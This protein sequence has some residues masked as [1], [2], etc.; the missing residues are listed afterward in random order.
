MAPRLH[1]LDRRLALSAGWALFAALLLLQYLVFV[2]RAQREITWAYPMHFDQTG[3]L[4]QSYE[5]FEVMRHEG[6]FRG[7]LHGL[8]VNAAQGKLLHLQAA[9][10]YLFLGASRLSALTLNFLYFALLQ[11]FAL[12]TTRWLTR[13]WAAGWLA[14]GFV[15]ASRTRLQPAGGMLDFRI[16]FI[17][18]C[19]VGILICVVI[20]SGVFRYR[21]WSLAAGAAAAVLIGFRFLS[22]VLVAPIWGATLAY[23][24]WGV[25]RSKAGSRVRRLALARIRG[26]LLASG[27]VVALAAPLIA[28]A[29][30]AIQPYYFGHVSGGEYKIRLAEYGVQSAWDFVLYYPLSVIREHLGRDFL[31]GLIIAVLVALT[32]ARRLEHALRGRPRSLF[33]TCSAFCWIALIAPLLVLT[34]WPSRS[35][36]VGTLLVGPVVAVCVVTL[37]W[38]AGRMAPLWN[39]PWAPAAPLAMAGVAVVAGALV[40]LDQARPALPATR[41]AEYRAVTEFYE[42]IGEYCEKSGLPMPRIVFDRIWD[43]LSPNILEP[44]YYERRG[45]LLRPSSSIG[46]HIFAVSDEEVSAALADCDLLVL[47]TPSSPTPPG[48]V[49]PYS[50]SMRGRYGMLRAVADREMV[51]LRKF[52]LFSQELTAFARPGARVDTPPDE[53]ITSAGATVRA[54]AFMLR[55]R[56]VVELTGRTAL[57]EFLGDTIGVHAVVSDGSRTLDEFDASMKTAEYYRLIL[58]LRPAT[59]PEEGEVTIRLTFN[60]H[61]VPKQAGVNDDTRQLVLMAPRR[62]RLLAAGTEVPQR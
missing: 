20:R 15:L 45:L 12:Y 32:S 23:L 44:L 42:H 6:L 31:L 58:P 11:W 1:L 43:F 10:L 25:W 14:V 2:H 8:K 3:Y 54:S 17:A 59:L 57:I 46:I 37:V 49:Y 7:V 40:D 39:V 56:P 19:L 60:K 52:T 38:L 24:A 50:E 41:P 55:L 35:P 47:T 9:C 26:L 53:W 13:S 28:V 27:V 18:S 16:D 4:A 30:P 36:V 21:N 33:R 5:T 22:A 62:V 34:A 51:P 29:W 61:V 48:A